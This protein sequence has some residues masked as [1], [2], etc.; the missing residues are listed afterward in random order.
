VAH[1]GE[2]VSGM[3]GSGQKWYRAKLEFWFT[4]AKIGIASGQLKRVGHMATL[5]FMW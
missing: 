2:P 4:K 5:L 3:E 1:S